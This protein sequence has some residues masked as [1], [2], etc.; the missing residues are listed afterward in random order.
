MT[1][2]R[3]TLDRGRVAIAGRIGNRWWRGRRAEGRDVVIAFKDIPYAATQAET[4]ELFR[5]DVPGI[6]KLVFLGYPDRGPS[7]K[8]A[9]ELRK[10]T[11][12]NIWPEIALAEELPPGTS[13]A[14]ATALSERETIGFGIAMCEM[15]IAWG[16][17]RELLT[18][19][20]RP[21]TVYIDGAPGSRCFTGATPR[22]EVVRGDEFES[23]SAP[24]TSVATYT[25]D[26][27]GFLTARLMWIGM[28]REDPY[29][30]PGALNAYDNVW[31]DR[32]RPWPGPPTLGRI[33]E[34]AL[35]VD[36]RLP[37]RELRDALRGL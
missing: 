3:G 5:Y 16:E 27:I 36:G 14:Q 25:A 15:A 7:P 31:R 6:A 19:G 18:I 12:R 26:D 2:R 22:V 4:D 37:V 1:E 23:F 9:D 13:L 17:R 10:L 28:F 20:I 30:F 8:N 24:A 29:K 32:R 33:L 11:A 21:E 35:V 34:R